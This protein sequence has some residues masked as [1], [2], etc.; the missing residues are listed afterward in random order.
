M[1]RGVAREPGEDHEELDPR[2]PAPPPRAAEHP[3]LA[4]QRAAGNRAIARVLEQQGRVPTLRERMAQLA[5][6]G[7]VDETAAAAQREEKAVADAFRGSVFYY[8]TTGGESVLKQFL[9]T[10]TQRKKSGK[11]PI[12]YYFPGERAKAY[13]SGRDVAES[14]GSGQASPEALMM[15]MY[16]GQAGTTLHELRNPAIGKYVH[17]GMKYAGAYDQH[18]SGRDAYIGSYSTGDQAGVE[19][20]QWPK[21]EKGANDPAAALFH[22]PETGEALTG[23]MEISR[24]IRDGIQRY[25]GTL[26]F[27]CK[28]VF[29]AGNFVPGAR[30]GDTNKE[31]VALFPHLAKHPGQSS[32]PFGAGRLVFHWGGKETV[33]TQWL[34]RSHWTPFGGISADAAETTI[35]KDSVFWRFPEGDPSPAERMRLVGK[36]AGREALKQRRAAEQAS[37]T[38]PK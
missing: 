18:T 35:P 14:E 8:G 10:L 36:E 34:F 23:T 15:D 12:D 31:A 25:G 26:V 30:Q 6:R 11:A 9:D 32:V 33:P 29:Q 21:N 28:Y 4:L 16:Y 37:G 3:L 5:G 19:G 7:L 27:E 22:H 2:R 38:A 1:P 20:W 24:L 13:I 17:E